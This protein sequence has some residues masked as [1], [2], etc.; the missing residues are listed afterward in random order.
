MN[1]QIFRLRSGE[2]LIC[3]VLEE[4]KTK[5][6]ISHPFVFKSTSMSDQQGSYDMTVLRDWLAQTNDKTVSIPKNHIVLQYE[7]KQDTVQLYN[8]QLESEKTLEEKIVSA[9]EPVGME[10][11][12]AQEQIFQDFLN[13]ILQDTADHFSDFMNPGFN[14]KD[15]TP[16]RRKR[17]HVPQTE[18]APGELDRHG[19]YVTMMIP[20]EAIMNLITAGILNPEDLLKMIKEVKKKNRFTGDEK[21]RTDFGNKLTDWNPDPG[22]DEYK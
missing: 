10:Q 7:P 14:L 12:P 9:D 4:T 2:E 20:S 15:T 11:M 17:K 5:I 22:S 18:I 16:K 8:L 6:K 19:I 1:L 3:Q 13:A 21:N